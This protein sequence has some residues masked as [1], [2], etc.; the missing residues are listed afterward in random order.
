MW[1]QVD[2]EGRALAGYRTTPPPTNTTAPQQQLS[3]SVP[4]ALGAAPSGR[5]PLLLLLVGVVVALA[6]RDARVSAAARRLAGLLRSTLSRRLAPLRARLPGLL[7]D[8]A[9]GSG[10]GEGMPRQ[11]QQQWRLG[12]AVEQ[13]GRAGAGAFGG[14]LGPRSPAY[15]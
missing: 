13:A 10:G 6:Q 8:G 4:P 15:S 9:S 12:V 7:Q 14:T 1:G 11:Q 3:P 2:A 5:T